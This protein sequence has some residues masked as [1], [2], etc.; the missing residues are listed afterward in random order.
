MIGDIDN[1]I[2]LATTLI[3]A[4]VALF[5]A[6][7]FKGR[8]WALLGLFSGLF[9]L[10]TLYYQVFF[11]FYDETP[12]YLSIADLS[13]YT[14]YLFL[15]MLVIYVNVHNRE[16][17]MQTSRKQGAFAE[18]DRNILRWARRSNPVIWIVPTFTIT[19]FFIFIQRGDYLLN[20]IVLVLMTGI[21]WHSVYG[22]VTIQSNPQ[23]KQRQQ[24][25]FVVTFLFCL[26]EYALWVSSLFWTGYTITNNYFW[27]DFLLSAM[28]LLFIPAVGR[29]VSEK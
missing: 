25:L 12:L 22:L 27:F 16:V 1:A 21:M 17:D 8:R 9:F 11:L 15:L 2:Q 7:K 26:T 6:V 4:I 19:M 23:R 3:C 5:R 18:M 28:F 10:G 29:T 20:F 24:M 14:S 13:W